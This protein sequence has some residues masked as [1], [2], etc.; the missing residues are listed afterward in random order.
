MSNIL[1]A[2]KEKFNY[3]KQNAKLR[4]ILIC[5]LALLLIFS[6]TLAWYIN[7][8]GMWGMEFN[9]GNIDFNAYVYSETG[10]KLAGPVAPDDENIGQYL[11]T[12]LVTLQNAQVGSVGT[13]YIAIESTGTIGI[14]YRL[15]F[16][17]R[18]QT[19]AATAYLGGYK[20]SITKVTDKV[21]FSG[22]GDIN[23]VNCPRPEVIDEEIVTIDRNAVNGMIEKKNGYDIYRF[24]YTLVN[25]NEEYTGHGINIFFNVFATQIGG[26]FDDTAERGLVY[27]C[28]TRD[29]LDRARVE[30]YPGDTIRL[31]SNI[32][33]YGD[34]VFN[35]P[36]NL[37]TNDFTLTVNG[38]LM[39]DYV[40]GNSL[41]LDAGGLGRIVVQCSKEGV[42]GNLKIKAP[43]SNV[44]LVGSNASIGDIVIEKTITVDATNA[45]GSAGLSLN[46]VR[47]VDEKNSNKNILLESNTRATVSFGTTV[48]LLQTVVK[49]NNIEIVNNG[50]IGDINLTNMALLEQ[51]NSPQ[52]YILN[53]NDINNPISL[54]AWSEKFVDDG[55]GKCTGN[56]RIIQSYSGSPMT[57]VGNCPFTDRHIEVEFKDTL[58]E[59][60]QEGNDS[61]LKIY[62]QDVDGHTTTIQS[63]LE[64]YLQNEATSGCSMNEI[65]Q[66][67][68]ISIGDKA[69]TNADIAF[70]NSNS[71]L[72]L[73]YLDLQRAHVYDTASGVYHRLHNNAFASVN[74]Y[75]SLI[76]PQNLVEIGDQALSNT[77]IDNAII[78]PSGV[79]TFGLKW[80]VNSQYVTF[81]AS[82]PDV[83]ATAG[84][85]GVHAIFVEEAY[86]SSYKSVYTGYANKIYPV[87]VLD[88]AKE[89][90]VRNTNR[91]EWEITYYIRGGDPIIGKDIT[92]DGKVLTITS[93]YANAYRHGYSNAN[94]Y[95]ADSVLNVGEG[96]FYNNTNVV[97]VDLNNV[98]TLGSNVFYQCTAL[99]SVVISNQLE[100]IGSG[101]FLGC[102]SLN[103]EIILP[104]TMQNIGANAFQKCPITRLYT[105]GTTSIE[106]GAFSACNLLVEADMPNVKVVGESG[107][108]ELF[109]NCS[110]LVSV[111]MPALVK[112]GG[113]RMFQFCGSLTELYM[114]ASEDDLTLGS[115]VFVGCN[116]QKLKLFVPEEH[117][118]FYQQKANVSIN[119][120]MIYPMGEKMGEQLV[121]GFNVGEYIVKNNGDNTYTMIT[122]NIS[123]S[124]E[125]S[126][127]LNFNGNP[128]TGIYTNCFRN[129]SFSDVK[130]NLGNNIKTIGDYAFY[131]LNGLHEVRFGKSH[132][133]LGSYTFAKCSNLSQ[134][135]VLPA[136]MRTIGD[137]TFSATPILSVNTG[138]TT[139]IGSY[140]FSTCSSLVYAEMPEVTV[141]AESGANE[142]FQNCSSLV[143]VDMPKVNKVSG[144]KMFTY[145]TS[146]RELYMGAKDA[147]LTLGTRPFA[148]VNSAQI[149][150]YV[151]EDAV[152]LYG[153]L[154]FISDK[155]IYPRGEKYGDLAV[156]GFVIGDYIFL[157]NGQEYTLVTSNLDF[158]GEVTIPETYKGLPVTKIYQNAFRNQSFTNVNMQLSDQVTAIGTRAFYNLEGLQSIKM[159]GVTTIDGEAFYKTGLKVLNGPKVTFIGNGGFRLCASLEIVNL[160]ELVRIDDDGVFMECSKLTTVYFEKV[161]SLYKTTFRYCSKLQKVTINRLISSDGSDMPATMT[162]EATA[163]CKIYV[164]YRSLSAY[165]STWSGKPVVSFEAAA[166]YNG[167]TY[168][169]RE[170]STGRFVVIDYI[171]SKS[172]SSLTVPA[173]VTVD[174]S[175]VSICGIKNGAFSTVAGSLKSI[176]LSA[177]MAQLDSAALSECAMLENIYVNSSSRYF[178]SVGGVLYSKDGKML[179][180]YPAG[181]AGKFD[182][183]A[184]G[185]ASTVVIGSNAFANAVKLTEIK[186]PASLLVI[187]GSAFANCSALHTVEF[188]GT[189]PPVLTA[190]G[191]FDTSVEGF[192]MVIPTT[193]GSVVTAYLCAYGFGEYERYIDRDG[194]AAPGDTYDRNK[195]TIG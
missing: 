184:S 172:G 59:Q 128:I 183:T 37:E 66:L 9:T 131:A 75:E 143:S 97:T 176:T 155:Q 194:Y 46:T 132:V 71:M 73:K 80:F 72:S 18:G 62:Y 174:G 16:D 8:L 148:N 142:L 167:D 10:K 92:I 151:P 164:P 150:L 117:L 82:V 110:S 185:P 153:S 112:A 38:N 43:L 85:T 100:T 120:N 129:Q 156:K 95:F 22:A 145:C 81:A 126:I 39:Y 169:L 188:T 88:E 113:N 99:S 123:H 171:P 139:T 177:A 106:G 124:G 40:L 189:T 162:F 4:M 149:K 182:M 170:S 69:V 157:K 60:I 7:S 44:S 34:L 137:S 86:I 63:I 102:K 98:K 140:V 19:E 64:N 105:G 168:I 116:M 26:D 76:L 173:T 13:V 186:F 17:V 41:K 136:T 190:S 51:T 65:L 55:A 165:P 32:I 25:K 146:L 20:Y 56:T 115:S 14:E 83:N 54:P 127:P 48:G 68:I 90:F 29:D 15:A 130:L 181:K 2:L 178:K 166:N 147:G 31:S 109:S 3:L 179:V 191:I 133:S 119:A 93:V 30:A 74:K 5:V 45:F 1:N 125:Y 70:M 101:A 187:D 11:N 103:Q 122:S 160:P 21:D 6:V 161:M 135:V 159:D 79:T 33:Y 58:V 180:K 134:D 35:K 163:P 23:V 175:S 94:I 154:G 96:N 77:R 114:A 138:G 111:N 42:G 108:N 158:S 24:D 89:H 192:K 27:Y 152:S 87:S 195:V 61:R 47:I 67:E 144:S 141:I 118:S 52:I 12:P 78:I 49:A 104:E 36:I 193:S 28:S 84:L 50:V 53:N 121:K 91:D 107:F 57:V